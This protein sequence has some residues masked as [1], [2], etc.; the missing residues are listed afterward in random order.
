MNTLRVL[1]CFV[2]I[3]LGI[4]ETRG[5]GWE[6]LYPD[7]TPTAGAQAVKVLPAPGG[8]YLLVLDE[9]ANNAPDQVKII[10][11]DENGA[12]TP[13]QTL[14]FGPASSVVDFIATSDG[15]YAVLVVQIDQVNHYTALLVKL[16]AQFGVLYQRDLGLLFPN[17]SVFGRRIVE[18]ALGLWVIGR[19]A[20]QTSGEGIKVCYDLA[21]NYLNS[22]TWGL[23]VSMEAGGATATPDGGVVAVG[24]GFDGA[25]FNASGLIATRFHPDGLS[26]LW[27]QTLHQSG[28]PYVAADVAAAP[29]GGYLIAGSRSSRGLLVKLDEQGAVQWQKELLYHPDS[30]NFLGFTQITPTADG[31]GYWVVGQTDSYIPQIGL[32]R[33]DLQG[34]K[35]WVKVFGPFFTYNYGHGLLALPDGG[36]LIAGSRT[37]LNSVPVPYVI[38]TTST[39]QTYASGVA[40]TVGDDFDNDC[41]ADVD[42][43]AFGFVVR[44]WANGVLVNSGTVGQ[45][46]EYFIPLDTGAYQITVQKPGPLWIFCPDTLHVTVLPQDT[47]SGIDFSGYFNQQPIDSLY[48]YVFE[49][50]DGDCIKDEF[51]PGYPGWTIGAVIT[52]QGQAFT[53]VATTD[54]AGYFV[55]TDLNGLT[56]ASQGFFSIAPP[57]NDGLNCTVTCPQAFSISFGDSTSY[58]AQFGVHCDSLPPCPVI[59]VDI[60]TNRLRPCLPATYSVHYCNNGSVAANEPSVV[61]TVDPALQVTGSSIPWTSASGN[62]YTFDLDT[63]APEDCGYFTLTVIVPCSDPVGTTYCVEA[64]AYPDTSCSAPGA[65]WD[66]SQIAVSAECLG[67][68]VL[69]TIQNVG[70]G[71]MSQPLDYIVI[72]DNVLLMQ[73]PGQFMLNSMQNLDVSY[74]ANGSFLRLEAM[75]APGYPGLKMPVAWA[76]GCGASGG[77][78]SLGFVN[79]YPLPDDDPWLD[80]FCLESTNSFDP[81]DKNGFPRGYSSEHFIAQNTDI[82]YLIRFQNTGT[83]PALEVE[84]RDTIPVQYLDPLTVRAGASSHPYTWDMQG[85][86]VV[87]FRFPGINLP[88]S[89]SSQEGSQGFVKFRVSQRPDLSKGTAIQNS[90]AIYFDQNAPV[91][92]NQTLHTVGKDFVVVGT[93]YSDNPGIRVTVAPNPASSWVG[94]QVDGAAPAES[95]QFRLLNNFGQTVL[96]QPIKGSYYGFDAGLLPYGLYFY[97]VTGGQ[98]RIASGKLVKM[99]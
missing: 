76:E 37:E 20:N 46:G 13:L 26:V 85:N 91:I 70:Q 14:N 39:G 51:E 96:Q 62:A 95:L 8:G 5:Q 27:D 77:N 6:R 61:V 87:V 63:L 90:A 44:A 16:N 36:C 15:G 56:N 66:G 33:F 58:Q 98:K 84:L 82:E 75:Q 3:V 31:T 89:A 47:V 23:P 80:I 50:Y 52:G 11:L 94:V 4:A 49:D 34:N 59:D 9:N 69:F 71:N 41:I 32:F 28:A 78:V 30:L 73:T 53:Q 17:F 92:T 45:H 83:A 29:D 38:R 1:T 43:L 40:G 54:S 81:N 64:H 35:Q 55:I 48:G 67:D 25:T 18:G 57:P 2:F 72:E 22:G 10:H 93:H 7:L 79:Q 68:S 12:A 74:P 21:G 19:T 60:A 97:E 86:G 65:N 99:Q 88:D 24:Q 42:T